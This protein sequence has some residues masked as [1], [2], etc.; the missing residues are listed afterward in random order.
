MSWELFTMSLA[1]A[2][3]EESLW[4]TFTSFDIARWP[5]EPPAPQRVL[6][7][8]D[9]VAALAAVDLPGSLHAVVRA[10]PPFTLRQGDLQGYG[11]A[12]GLGEVDIQAA[13][14]GYGDMLDP[15]DAVRL[16]SFRKPDPGSVLRVA[17]AV[18]ATAGVIAFDA[19][20]TGVAI[21]PGEG[22]DDIRADWPW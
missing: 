17:C 12:W 18:A 3:A 15:D 11:E 7:V 4:Q 19:D 1:S 21:L 13:G 16:L 2:A 22:P 9:V 5:A 6:L 20:F 8:R 14:R 10:D